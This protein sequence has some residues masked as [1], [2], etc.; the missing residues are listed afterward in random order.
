MLFRSG[1]K[2][3]QT[4]R[5]YAEASFDGATANQLI[6]VHAAESQGATT[7]QGFNTVVLN[8]LFVG[9]THVAAICSGVG[10][11]VTFILP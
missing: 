6:T 4:G 11:A 5:Y 9:Q 3:D 7:V 8:E 2:T 1:P 10:N